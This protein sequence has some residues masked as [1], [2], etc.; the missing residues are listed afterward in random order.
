MESYWTSWSNSS[1]LSP[2]PQKTTG[3][4]APLSSRRQERAAASLLS[5]LSG[6]PQGI[7]L[8]VKSS[9][10][11]RT[12]EKGPSGKLWEGRDPTTA[13][14]MVPQQGMRERK[15]NP[16]PASSCTPVCRNQLSQDREAWRINMTGT[17]QKVI[18]GYIIVTSHPGIKVVPEGT[19]S[20]T[21]IFPFFPFRLENLF[22]TRYCGSCHHV[23]STCGLLASRD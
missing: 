16:P 8:R 21:P 1:H 10:G 2:P 9:V 13:R 22:L 11:A 18:N 4:P 14:N 19:L 20:V 5:R 23:T 15:K 17:K 7:S 3:S 12:T 6:S